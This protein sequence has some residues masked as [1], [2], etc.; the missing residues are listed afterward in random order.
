M[1]KIIPP[2]HLVS[3]NCWKFVPRSVPY[4]RCSGV[5][6]SWSR[7]TG[8]W[9]ANKFLLHPVVILEFLSCW[10]RRGV[11]TERCA[12]VEPGW[13]Y[14][15]GPLL[16]CTN[17]CT[18]NA[19]RP[20]CIPYMILASVHFWAVKETLDSISKPFLYLNSNTIISTFK[21][22]YFTDIWGEKK[23]KKSTFCQG[24]FC[25]VFEILFDME[26]T[27]MNFIWSTL[28]VLASAVLTSRQT[29]NSPSSCLC[30]GYS[31][32]CDFTIIIYRRLAILS[33]GGFKSHTSVFMTCEMCLL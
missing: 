8:I 1:E 31:C 11:V 24:V 22:L 25:K 19:S 29:P 18:M 10:M 13:T 4:S 20:A 5:T 15:V 16:L 23:L 32:L 30:F 28:C 17:T 2:T 3:P 26:L 6:L 21:S 12:Q 7:K 14:T 27:L 9:D 33:E